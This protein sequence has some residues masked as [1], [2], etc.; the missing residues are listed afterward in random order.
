MPFLPRVRVALNEKLPLTYSHV[1]V[2]LKSGQV[3]S[4]SSDSNRP[5]IDLAGQR[6]R[7]VA[8]FHK[9]AANHL[10]ESRRRRFVAAVLSLEQCEDV[11]KL[12][13]LIQS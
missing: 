7:L 5:A 2:H 10:D 13:R 4:D 3:I 6:E 1:D 12:F 9:L 11:G 8:K